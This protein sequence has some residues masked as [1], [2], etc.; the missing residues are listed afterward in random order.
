MGMECAKIASVLT[1]TVAGNGTEQG[2]TWT[3]TSD[4][5][6]AGTWYFAYK[7]GILV[8]DV[9]EGTSAGAIVVDAPDGQLTMPIT[10]EYLMATELVQ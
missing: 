7:K 3:M 1:G 10:R 2:A 6:G 9:T 4:L 8:S 5:D